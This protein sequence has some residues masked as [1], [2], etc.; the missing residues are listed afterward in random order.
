KQLPAMQ[1]SNDVEMVKSAIEMVK[2]LKIHANEAEAI[3]NSSFE[4]Q[5]KL[6]QM[7]NLR[8]R[9]IQHLEDANAAIVQKRRAIREHG[10]R[11][12]SKA[13]VMVN[14]SITSGTK[15]AGRES[16]ITLAGDQ[17][18]C[19]IHELKNSEGTSQPVYKMHI[20]EI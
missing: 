9:D 14:K 18:R 6:L 3:I 1:D 2:E 19:R 15:V 17:R 8:L 16:R 13:E 5:D 12:V 20:S 11:M 7:I 10:R 4:Q